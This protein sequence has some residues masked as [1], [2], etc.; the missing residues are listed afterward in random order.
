MEPRLQARLQRSGWDLAAAAYDGSWRW[1]FARVHARLM[2]CSAPLPGERVL[3]VACGTGALALDAAQAVCAD[4]RVVG[5]DLSGRMV[6]AARRQ[7]RLHG[8]AHVAFERMD[9]EHLRLRDASFDVALCALGLMYV[10]SPEGALR[11]MRRVLRPGG[12]LG[13]AIW[14]E[15]RR[16]GWSPVFSIVDAEVA[17][18]VCPMFFRLGI[19]DALAQACA[20]AGFVAVETSRLDGTLDYAHAGE[21]CRAAFVGG[22]VA[23]AWDR[24][25][26]TVRARV[27]ERYV[28]SIG[29]WRSGGG[30]RVPAQ[31][32][33]VH[34]AVPPEE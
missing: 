30:Y 27:C 28:A 5:I 29:R 19:G 4:G 24:F 12:R 9:A 2:E 20:D 1:P 17:S 31:F 16:C 14:G 8:V 23:L 7:A 26:D 13:I 3:D 25:D 32:V 10:P 6:D 33:V 15:P 21:A 22:P 34:A 11:E 18:E